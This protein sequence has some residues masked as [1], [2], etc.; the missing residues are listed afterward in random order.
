[1]YVCIYKIIWYSVHTNVSCIGSIG[2][3]DSMSVI[4]LTL[5]LRLTYATITIIDVIII[6]VVDFNVNCCLCIPL[7][8]YS[9]YLIY[10]GLFAKS[11]EHL[12]PINRYPRST[13]K[14]CLSIHLDLK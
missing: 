12:L 10:S 6:D 9:V 2:S 8:Y 11:Y 7:I 1:M 5:D 3:I 13:F 4:I 14:S